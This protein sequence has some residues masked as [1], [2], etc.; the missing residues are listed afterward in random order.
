TAR[1]LL[2]GMLPLLDGLLG[3]AQPALAEMPLPAGSFQAALVAAQARFPPVSLPAAGAPR[4]SV[5]IPVFG[6]FEL[7]HNCLA[8]VADLPDRTPFEV[9]LVDDGSSDETLLAPLLVRNMRLLRN[10]ATQGFLRSCN[11]GAAM[12]R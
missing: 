12:A 6:K 1:G 8:T 4:V 2:D 3:A 11:T 9:I 10:Q 7:T 5:I